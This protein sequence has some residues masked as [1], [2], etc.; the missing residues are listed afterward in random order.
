MQ[1]LSEE[2]FYDIPEIDQELKKFD[3]NDLIIDFGSGLPSSL[4]ELQIKYGLSNFKCF[5]LAK[6]EKEIIEVF[7]EYSNSVVSK[8][9]TLKQCH[10]LRF[11]DEALRDSFSEAEI[12]DITSNS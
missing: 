3:R 9:E 5:D 11:S 6:S 4:F 12:Q 2:S 8:Y 7:S 1:I 10:E